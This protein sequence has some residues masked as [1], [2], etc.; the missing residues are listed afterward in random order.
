MR[1]LKLFIIRLLQVSWIL[2]TVICVGAL[3]GNDASAA[4]PIF[5]FLGLFLT[6][7]QYLV[8]SNFKP[9]ELF[10]GKL[11]QLVKN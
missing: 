11:I 8:F 5:V 7:A 4:F 1:G 2:L 6:I 3:F 10:N 9:Y